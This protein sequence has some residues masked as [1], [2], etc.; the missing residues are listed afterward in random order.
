MAEESVLIISPYVVP[1]EELREHFRR[2]TA[3]GVDITIY[4]NSLAATDHTYAFS[5]YAKYRPELL[6]MGIN[7]REVKPNGAI[8]SIHQ[9]STS[10]ADHIALHGKLSVFDRRWVYVGS[11][12]LDA[13]SAFWNTELGILVDS[14]EFAEQV[15]EDFTADLDDDSSWR[16][17][18]RQEDGK[19]KGTLVWRSG[20]E[21]LASEPS[22]GKSQ[23]VSNWFYSLF[24]LDEQL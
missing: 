19:K 24:K 7:L 23:K 6:E 22:R 21:E 12:N 11:F 3:D 1:L 5:G 18:L 4:T 13:R 17:E 10:P 9:V 14:P 16:V 20:D 2:R 8:S 15:L